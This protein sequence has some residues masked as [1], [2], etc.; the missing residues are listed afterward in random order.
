MIINY[1]LALNIRDQYYKNQKK[2]ERINEFTEEELAK[3]TELEIN[4]ADSIEDLDKLPNLKKITIKSEN[5]NHFDGYVDLEDN[6]LINRIRDFSPLETLVN[7]EELEIINDINIKKLNLT[8][9]TNLKRLYLVNNQQLTVV[10][11]LEKLKKLEN[12]IIYGT[13]IKNQISFQEYLKNTFNAQLNIL[14]INMYH[15]L[16][17]GSPQKSNF[18][19]E[20][21]RLGFNKVRFAEKTGF[22][23]FALLT[24]AQVNQLFQMCYR[25]IK[26]NKL[27]HL[28]KYDR[29]KT[30]YNYVT[31]NI[32]F[33]KEGIA[34]RDQKF[35]E[36]S[37]HYR[38]KE[39]PIHLKNEFSMLHS[40]YNAGILKKSNCEG[41]VN[42]MNF[43]L[44]MLDIEAVSVYAS[45]KQ[46]RYVAL[47][48]HALTSVKLDGVWYYCEPT[49][50]IPGE[51]KYFMKTYEE[52]KQTHNLNP[53]ER[54][55]NKDVNVDVDNFG[56]ISRYY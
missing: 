54:L 56:R 45:D 2:F 19:A 53:L 14:D 22:A 12:I 42:L 48:N 32:T 5:Y 25:F 33:D 17:E 26:S 24:P 7:L 40:S 15:S 37:N 46:T 28:S 52:I 3:V 6:P 55:K 29:I 31:T 16:V 35:L 34:K 36:I 23:D 20:L 10:K 49:W 21:Y 39:I 13:N 8:K 38:N 18:Y 50:E 43:M 11:N 41:Y 51:F 4:N 47:Y 30:I 44:R 9:L 27:H 1:S